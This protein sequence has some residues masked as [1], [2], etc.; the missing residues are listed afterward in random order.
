MH[1]A[2]G[3][4]SIVRLIHSFKKGVKLGIKNFTSLSKEIQLDKT[5]FVINDQ[6]EKWAR[7]LDAKK[8]EIPR[9][10][11]VNNFGNAGTVVHAIFEEHIP[12]TPKNK[13]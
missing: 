13:P 5:R 4:A 10:G 6:D 3:M 1:A 11:A 12:S 7:L 9:R 8:N 2:S